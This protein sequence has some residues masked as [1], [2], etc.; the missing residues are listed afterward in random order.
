MSDKT[1]APYGS[2]KSPIT[3]D[4]LTR[5][6]VGLGQVAT[7]GDNVYWTEMRPSE[8]GRNALVM[9]RPNGEKKDIVPPPFNVRSRVHEYGGGAFAVYDDIL[10]FVDAKDQTVYSLIPGKSPVKVLRKAGT[11]FADF[12]VDAKRRRLICVAEDLSGEGEAVN[13][14]VAIGFD[15]SIDTLVSGAD[16]YAAPKLSPDGK[17]LAWIE[18]YHPNMPWDGTQLREA[19]VSEGGDLIDNRPIAGGAEESIFQ[20]EYAPDGSL[21]Y[22]SDRS[23][24]WNIYCYGDVTRHYSFD[25]E[26]GLPHWIFGMRTYGFLGDGRIICTYADKGDWSLGVIDPE[27]GELRRLDLPWCTYDG[28]ICKGRKAWFHGGRVDSADEIVELDIDALEAKV[29]RRS[30]E[31]DVE[32]DGISVAKLIEFPTTGGRT[33]YGYYYPPANAAYSAPEGEKPPLIVKSHGGPTGQSTKSLSLKFQYWTSRGFAVLDVNYSGSTG[34]GRAYRERLAGQWGIAD[35]D[36]CARAAEYAVEKGL[37]DPERL[38]IVGGSAGGYT[39]LAALAFRDVFK[40]GC[41]SYGVGD[42]TALANDTHKFESRYLDK[43]VGRWPEDADIYRERSPLNHTE[44]LNCPILFLQGDEDKVVPPN[45]AEAMVD[46]LREKSMPVAYLLFEGEGHGF[47]RGE[48]I[49]RALEAELSFYAQIF[50]F[51][52]ADSVEPLV[53]ENL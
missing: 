4:L 35:V 19:T 7:D 53:I 5:G 1:V 8:A 13:S 51:D 32:A 12:V 6:A 36:D 37:A 33:A 16:F 22:V 21:H 46:A 48:T 39:T 26:F 42:L 49:K 14:L 20:P 10:W 34:F 29:L 11:A 17:R 18:W 40:A 15:G 52:P 50:G 23:G 2:W 9:E 45:Q 24:F 27:S 25:Y 47:R 3:T 44:R 31:L 30:V 28:L 43:L 41:S 38:I